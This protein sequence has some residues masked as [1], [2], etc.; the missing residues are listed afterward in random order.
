M[1]EILWIYRQHLKYWAKGGSCTELILPRIGGN[2]KQSSV[3]SGLNGEQGS[4]GSG[5][6]WERFGWLAPTSY[7]RTSLSAA[8][9]PCV[10][11][12]WVEIYVL[13]HPS[14][15]HTHA[16][17]CSGRPVAYPLPFAPPEAIQ[18]PMIYGLNVKLR[19]LSWMLTLFFCILSVGF[20]GSLFRHYLEV[21]IMELRKN[22]VR[23]FID[24]QLTPSPQTH[25]HTAFL[26]RRWMLRRPT[27]PHS[28]GKS[29]GKTETHNTFLVSFLGTKLKEESLP[30]F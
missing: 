25:F 21:K 13:P 16:Y 17:G 1:L 8:S 12:T 10:L 24:L 11:W 30:C 18:V 26:A 9:L 23:P 22:S 5:L 7:T 29:Y 15:L 6:N 3:S 14:I 2:E 27:L 19:A 4:P 28:L 20:A